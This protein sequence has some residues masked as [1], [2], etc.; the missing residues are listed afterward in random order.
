M[1]AGVNVRTIRTGSSEAFRK[2]CG[3]P[4]GTFTKSPGM[5][6]TRSPSRWNVGVPYST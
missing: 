3:V 6:T 5:A 4:F 1:P 2:L